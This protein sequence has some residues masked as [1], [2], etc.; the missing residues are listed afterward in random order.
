MTRQERRA[1]QRRGQEPRLAQAG[2]NAAAR[3]AWQSPI[4]LVTLAALAIGAIIIVVASGI[5]APRPTTPKAPLQLTPV[6]LV[7]AT[8]ARAVGS[9][10]APVTV[11][12]WS[13]FQCPACKYFFLNTEP[14]FVE[15]YVATGKAR[16]VYRDYAFIDGGVA[17]G[18][19]QQAAAAARC[20]GD[21]GLFWPFHDYLFSNQGA[22]ENGGT[23]SSGFLG[24]IADATK[25]NRS[26]FD[27]CMSNGA[28]A[29]VADVKAETVVGQGKQISQTPTITVNGGIVT[30]TGST[31]GPGG[32]VSLA[33][34]G[35]A[36]DAAM[37]GASPAPMPSA[38][39]A[40]TAAAGSPATP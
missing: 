23:F 13:D 15:Q 30:P 36:V 3:P 16:L 9:A 1:A 31:N 38:T 37:A 8:N 14:G 39:P 27:S 21:Q 22:K 28:T 11:E 25:L 6:G 18:E 20:A 24:A 26:T 10:G 19:S 17:T 40:S 34:L 35:A 32:A 29:K 12:V 2:T 5:L 4:L 7:D 33:Q